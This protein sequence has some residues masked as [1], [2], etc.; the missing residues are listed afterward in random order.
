MPHPLIGKYYGQTNGTNANTPTWEG[1]FDGEQ[2][3]GD[4]IVVAFANDGGST[5][6]SGMDDW[7][8]IGT[9]INTAGVRTGI[10]Y[11]IRS[12]GTDIPEPAITG[13]TNPWACV[14]ILLRGLDTDAPL[15][16]HV[17]TT[18]S[19]NTTLPVCPDATTTADRCLV[20]RVLGLDA[21]LAIPRMAPGTYEMVCAIGDSPVSATAAVGM[22]MI[23]QYQATAGAVGTADFGATNN[24]GG[25]LATFALKIAAGTPTPRHYKSI[26]NPIVAYNAPAAS[27]WSG[28]V[29]LST[30]IAELDGVTVQ[31]GTA[32][33]PLV[34]TTASAAD[35]D[36]GRFGPYTELRCVQAITPNGPAGYYGTV[37]A[38]PAATDF[39]NQLFACEMRSVAANQRPTDRTYIFFFDVDDNWAA[40]A[41][42]TR[43]GWTSWR[44]LIM[45]LASMT[46]AAQSVSAIDWEG[47]TKVGFAK[48]STNNTSTTQ[49]RTQGLQFRG[50]LAIP[51]GTQFASIHGNA[52]PEAVLELLR[53]W[54]CPSFATLQGGVQLLARLPFQI[55]DKTTPA[56]FSGLGASIAFPVL[57]DFHRPRNNDLAIKVAA[58]AADAID[59][60]ALSI[61]S[62]DR[63]VKFDWDAASDGDGV[64]GTAAIFIGQNMT[65]APDVPISGATFS[66]CCTVVVG[67]GTLDG[68]T[69]SASVNATAA[70]S[71]TDGA[72]I[73]ECDFTKGAETYAIQIAGNGPAAIDLS[74]TIF[75]GYAK[76]LN[77]T[78]TTGTVTIT[79]AA[80]QEK[81]TY[82]SA[83]VTVAWDQFIPGTSWTN[84]NLADGTSVLVRN[85]TTS[86][87]IDYDVTSGGTGYTIA[88]LPGVD[89]T[90]G[91]TVEIRL[92]RKVLKTYFEPR[93]IVI[94]TTAGGGDFVN[95]SDL[96]SCSVCDAL[97]MDGEDYDAKFELDYI[98]DELDIETAGTWQ[99]GELMAW[100]Q[101]QMTLQTPM[102]Q[103][104][105]A[106]V[107]QRDGSFLNDVSV[108]SSLVDTTETGDSVETTGR[109]IFRSDG[110]RPI[111]SPT[112]GGGAIDLSWRDP[113]TVVSTGSG[114]LPSDVTAI[115]G[116]TKTAMEA[117]AA[118]LGRLHR[119]A[120]LKAG[121]PLTVTPTS[122]VVGDISQTIA[123]DGTTLTTVTL[124]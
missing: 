43:N 120:G 27:A 104:W 11:R 57:S 92:S 75:A 55:G 3:D 40:F 42:M 63:L 117:D 70:A 6:F 17:S 116:A 96:A 103:F 107:I 29:N 65:L 115:A 78:G 28:A 19:T 108:M 95:V 50:I 26:T 80:G 58:G 24:D 53:S 81:P 61:A 89:Y 35:Q 15:N 8:E 99:T 68:C 91:D 59:F 82:D 109:R 66:S 105:G 111:K 46:P 60:S 85:V 118:H 47:V 38:L 37:A 77:L 101:W 121:E 100:W 84:E 110:A 39:K 54:S 113:V 102:E 86:T 74:D 14:A 76:P 10:W 30:L 32:S 12:G 16:V 56:S 83:G 90:V 7:T 2:A 93:T 119:L 97:D 9:T 36:A 51:F 49:T 31:T 20:F 94:S 87:T 62:T 33:S 4:V 48:Y 122:R 21:M 79:L 23:M 112:T 1:W 73:T 114:V 44:P 124:D 45:A 34:A 25:R 123:G 71:C 106:W 72:A 18:Q 98:D 5:A 13:T 67:A 52:D 22:T 69:I 88:M 41:P 64:D